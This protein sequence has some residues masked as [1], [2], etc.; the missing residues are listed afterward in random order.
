MH[1]RFYPAKESSWRLKNQTYRHDLYS[2]IAIQ[3]LIHGSGI[4]YHHVLHAIAFAMSLF[5][6]QALSFANAAHGYRP[7]RHVTAPQIHLGAPCLIP[8]TRR[9][10]NSH[11]P[12][13]CNFF[14][15]VRRYLQFA[16]FRQQSVPR[17][18]QQKHVLRCS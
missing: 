15:Y 11:F 10:R 16:T 13:S 5:C 2:Y 6:A 18:L 9:D 12:S 14:E 4:N 8:L 3:G 1:T 7:L 17:A